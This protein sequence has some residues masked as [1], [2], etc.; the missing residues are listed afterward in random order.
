MK[1][2]LKDR[3]YELADYLVQAAVVAVL[4]GIVAG[5]AFLVVPRGSH[6]DLRTQGLTK[7]ETSL[8]RESTDV[9]FRWLKENGISSGRVNVFVSRNP[10]WLAT[11]YAERREYSVEGFDAARGAFAA[12]TSFAVGNDVYLALEE[13]LID[14]DELLRV[15]AHEVFHVVQ[16]RTA[17]LDG[18][19]TWI[20]EGFAEYVA[21][22]VR[23]Q[24]EPA[25]AATL[26][27]ER[28]RAARSVPTSLRDH[29]S[30]PEPHAGAPAAAYSLG[31]LAVDHL[32]ESVVDVL[33]MW[34]LTNRGLRW[35]DAF[36]AAYG[37]GLS[38]FYDSFE[39]VRAE[40]FPPYPD[41]VRGS[42]IGTAHE[43]SGVAICPSRQG[44]RTEECVASRV[45]AG[46][47]FEF[48]LEPG[49]YFAITYVVSDGRVFPGTFGPSAFEV[50]AGDGVKELR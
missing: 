25:L 26:G 37:M 39:K 33:A 18:T 10:D 38:D 46:G 31:V 21:D 12:G 17:G 5:I 3:A 24:G 7:E 14:S 44:V 8:V 20:I 35:E 40:Q 1:S 19:P 41:G 16:Y 50:K 32:S 6:S 30:Q 2:W 28:R 11:N 36:V 42:V 15:I 34:A 23:T 47:S 43:A 22:A 13:G 45:P 4:L 49:L 27:Q 9:T 29:V 48:R